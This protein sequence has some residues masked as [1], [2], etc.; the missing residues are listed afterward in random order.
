MHAGTFEERYV[1]YP[2]CALVFVVFEVFCN[3]HYSL[4]YSEIDATNPSVSGGTEHYYLSIC[5]GEA[6]L[7]ENDRN[8]F[9]LQIV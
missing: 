1:V 2:G 4:F 8:I 7:V 9:L 3:D 6:H 5:T